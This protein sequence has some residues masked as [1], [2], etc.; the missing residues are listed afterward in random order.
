MLYDIISEVRSSLIIS[1]LSVQERD[2]WMVIPNTNYHIASRYNVIIFI[3]SR[4]LNIIFFPLVLSPSRSA[5]KHKLI[6]VDFF[7]NSH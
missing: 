3:L 1:D 5:S 4:N 7:N 6:I 2:K